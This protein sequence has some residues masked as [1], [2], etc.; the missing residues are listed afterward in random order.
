MFLDNIIGEALRSHS[1][2][3]AEQKALVLF[4]GV[5]IIVTQEPLFMA[6]LKHLMRNTRRPIIFTCE[7][8]PEQFKKFPFP[9]VPWNMTESDVTS[10]VLWMS[11]ICF[12]E[13]IPVPSA[14]ALM[15][16]ALPLSSLY[17]LYVFGVVSVL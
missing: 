9:V 1:V 5:D 14:E 16:F 4:E 15:R 11:A 13:G 12:C 17:S 3:A 10:M 8:V 7:A 6:A 2:T